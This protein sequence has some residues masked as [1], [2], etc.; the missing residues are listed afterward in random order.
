MIEEVQNGLNHFQETTYEENK[1]LYTELTN[2]QHPHTLFIGCS[3][4]RV[5][6]EKL[7]NAEPGDVFTIRNI[8]NTVPSSDRYDSDLTTLS[9]VEYAVDVLEVKEIIV[10]GHSNCGGCGAVLSDLNEI[11]H[12]P[13]TQEYLKPVE[14]VRESIQEKLA[15]KNEEEKAQILEQ[16]N[17]IEQLTHLK[18]YSFITNRL[19]QGTLEIEGWHYTI[20]TGD[21]SVYDERENKFKKHSS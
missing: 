4:S 8:A 15:R 12:L 19:D 7:L 16:A 18:E 1:E 20:G 13:Y 5:Q 3:D 10:C 9:A 2:Q 21:V 17:V 14:A 6:V 11:P